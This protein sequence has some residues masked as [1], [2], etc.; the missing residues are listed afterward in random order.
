MIVNFPEDD[1][2]QRRKAMYNQDV[3]SSTGLRNQSAMLKKNL[4]LVN[5][6]VNDRLKKNALYEERDEIRA[7]RLDKQKRSGKSGKDFVRVNEKHIAK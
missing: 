3:L 7:K 2:Y 4:N 5:D 1:D 6:I